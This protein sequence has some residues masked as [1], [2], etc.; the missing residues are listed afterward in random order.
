MCFL[1]CAA[2]AKERD[3]GMKKVLMSVLFNLLG[4]GA[5]IGA[6]FM[7]GN[8]VALFWVVLVSVVAACL[9]ISPYKPILMFGICLIM[10]F[11]G[12]IVA[13][14]CW[15]GF[16]GMSAFDPIPISL[17]LAGSGAICILLPFIIGAVMEAVCG[18][19]FAE[20]PAT[21][22]WSLL[23]LAGVLLV[24]A[25]AYFGAYPFIAYQTGDY[26]VY[27]NMY[28]VKEF[29]IPDG[30][31]SLDSNIFRG[32]ESLES[33]TVPDSVTAMNIGVF[34]DLKNL[35][36]MTIPGS[37]TV[38]NAEVLENCYKLE[39]VTLGE[40][41]DRIPV[42]AFRNCRSLVC[43]RIPVSVTDIGSGAFDGCSCLTDIYYGGT[44]AQWEA[45]EKSYHWD[46]DIPDYTVHCADG[47]ISK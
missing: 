5:V 37:V 17:A 6:A 36:E 7:A 22:K 30:V 38:I 29:A 44:K 35:K 39:N 11:G 9:L 10:A 18:R 32:C 23:I 24:G 41:V 12:L 34:S 15:F 4:V 25:L 16:D 14:V 26:S 2:V 46:E 1:T 3:P 40:G 45:I 19:G 20:Q 47:E 31:T 8:G 13:G 43:V 21:V 27:I 42:D 28:H 33:I